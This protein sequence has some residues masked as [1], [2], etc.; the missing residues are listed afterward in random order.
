MEQTTPKSALIIDTP[1][2][3]SLC[4]ANQSCSVKSDNDAKPD[5]CP[6]K[7]LHEMPKGPS[8][9]EY[10]IGYRAGWN[11]FLKKLFS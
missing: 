11:A 8:V 1:D 7:P 4:K 6:L 3:C 5:S 9:A 10:N 2:K